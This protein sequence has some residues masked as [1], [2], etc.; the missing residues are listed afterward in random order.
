MNVVLILAVS[1]FITTIVSAIGRCPVW[2][3]VMLLCV[4]ALLQT[5]PL[6]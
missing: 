2:V 6:R 5:L 4:V 3:P 1:A